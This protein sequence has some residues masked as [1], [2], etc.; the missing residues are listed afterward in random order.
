MLHH[1]LFMTIVILPLFIRRKAYESLIMVRATRRG[2]IGGRRVA[3]EFR[4]DGDENQPQ[5]VDDPSDTEVGMD[6]VLYKEDKESTVGITTKET[7][8]RS[9][10]D[11]TEKSIVESTKSEA[12]PEETNVES[13]ESRGD[14]EE[15]NQEISSC[16][17]EIDS[18]EI[19][20]QKQLDR[21]ARK[22]RVYKHLGLSSSKKRQK[23]DEELRTKSPVRSK[24]FFSAEAKRS[25]DADH[26]RSSKTSQKIMKFGDNIHSSHTKT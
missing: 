11:E 6:L 26:K 19:S 9:E 20:V 15:N 24:Y 7:R 23:Q 12:S 22:K 17:E 10:D 8:S 13:E 14:K 16:D 18:T 21:A 25:L 2:P 4:L 1:V 5:L 3:C